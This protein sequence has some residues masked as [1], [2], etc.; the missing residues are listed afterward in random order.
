MI[1]VTSNIKEVLQAQLD[2]IR[3]L[4]N[5][6]NPIMRTVALTVL[7]EMRRRIH[8]DGK[9]SSG[10]AIGTYS[11]GYMRMRTG[12]SKTGP[13]HNRTSDPKVILSLTRQM[14]ND[15]VVVPTPRGYGIGY[16][17]PLNFKK[18]GW[19]E[20]T[21]KKKILTKLTDQELELAVTTAQEFT[22]EYLKTL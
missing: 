8:V 21:Y 4:K 20:E 15:M 3:E 9:D 17:N 7:P 5:N 22:P 19:N 10:N 12:K 13:R 2:K 6:P 1:T 11:P 18:A 14:E 16:N